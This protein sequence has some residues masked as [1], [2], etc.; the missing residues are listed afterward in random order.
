M[1]TIIAAYFVLLM[2]V[3]TLR[4]LKSHVS[5]QCM[6]MAQKG[7]C[8]GEEMPDGCQKEKCVLNL[9]FSAGQF[10]VQQI[11][12]LSIPG[13][14]EKETKQHLNYA[15]NLIPHFYNSFWHPP[16]MRNV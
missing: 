2:G 11:Q 13:I 4:V 5:K 9:N 10:I 7:C 1:T 6:V 12:D 16:E 14:F 3:P 8:Q 15:K